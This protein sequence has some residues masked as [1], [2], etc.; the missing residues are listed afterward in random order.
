MT[1]IAPDREPGARVSAEDDVVVSIGDLGDH[2][3][4]TITGE[5]DIVG[6]QVLRIVAEPR[7]AGSSRPLVIDV[8]RVS[9]CD[10]AGLTALL[11][12]RDLAVAHGREVRLR[13]PGARLRWLMELTGTT[14]SFTVTA[15]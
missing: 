2:L 6:A 12:L 13:R 3:C 5:L 7:L 4:V 9:F 14:A 10:V 15:R 11:S 8:A 1:T